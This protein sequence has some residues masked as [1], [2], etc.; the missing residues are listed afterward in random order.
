MGLYKHTAQ[1]MDPTTRNEEIIMFYGMLETVYYKRVGRAIV[2][3]YHNMT[4]E[5]I[6]D[7]VLKERG[8]SRAGVTEHFCFITYFNSQ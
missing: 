3:D 4:H 1:Q 7:R 8:W 6:I 5:Q 2:D